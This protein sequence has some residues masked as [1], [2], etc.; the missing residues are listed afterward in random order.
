MRKIVLGLFVVAFACGRPSPELVREPAHK[1]AAVAI[2]NVAVLDVTSGTRLEAR[3]VIVVGDRIRSVAPAGQSNVPE[4]AMTIDGAGGT[5]LPGLIDIHA[6]VLGDSW[7][8]GFRTFPDPDANL[9][10]YLYCGVTTVLDPADLPGQIFAKRDGVAKGTL[11]G[12]RIYAAGPMVTAP[13]GHPI[14]LFRV[15]AP[16]WLRWYLIPRATIE[17]GDAEAGRKAADTVKAMGADFVKVAIDRIP[18]DCPIIG[19]AALGALGA[20]AK[21][22]GLRP[23]AHIGTTADAVA[24]AK[25]GAAAWMHGVYRER[26]PDEKIAELAAFGIPMSPTIV[27][28]ES[29]ALLFQEKRVATALER[30]TNPADVLAGFDSPPPGV[31]LSIF[32]DYLATLRAH[33]DDW[34]D[35]VRRLHGAGVTMLAGSDAQA[36][37]FPGAGLHRELALLVESGLTPAEAI[38]AATIDPARF[39]ADG[40]EPEFGAVAEGKIADLLLV[41]GDPTKD[42]A[43]VSRIRTVVKG[44]VPLERIAIAR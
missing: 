38:R 33:R 11:L 30:E 27:V 34:R 6:H 14:P 10:A 17:V 21:Q 35:N 22:I 31:D 39:L 15:L 13:G 9:R 20:E 32:R 1:P 42:V 25:A 18:D 28:F 44:G 2:R 4:D 36:S 8:L 40:K 41:D 23:I 7:P 5:L 16:W 43:A 37:V 24:A 26:I 3:D 12:P 19:D 29:Y